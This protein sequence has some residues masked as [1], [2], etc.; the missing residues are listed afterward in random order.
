[1]EACAADVENIEARASLIICHGFRGGKENGG[2]IGFFARQANAIGLNVLAFDF[3]GSGGSTGDF[4]S[5]S[6]SRQVEDLQA[7]IDYQ[8]AKCQLPV[9][10]LGRSFGGSTVLAGGSADRRVRAF[11]FWSTPVRLQATFKRIIPSQYNLK[12]P[13]QI[14]NMSD[15]SGD[16]QVGTGLL[17]DFNGHDM[18]MY[19]EAIGE[20]PLLVIQGGIDEVVDPE[21]ALLIARRSHAVLHMVPEADHQFTGNTEFRERLTIEWLQLSLP[22]ISG[23]NV[24]SM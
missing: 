23:G 14:I 17:A 18:D 15:E 21:D 11:V 10:L 3:T 7:V 20:R 12:G 22:A 4:S 5:V 9:I 13:E 8:S 19:I 1:M 24:G 6:L 16:Y 2:R